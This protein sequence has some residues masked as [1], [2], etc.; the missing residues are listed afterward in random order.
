[1]K[2]IAAQ[3]HHPNTASYTRQLEIEGVERPDWHLSISDLR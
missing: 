1:M 2:K 3:P